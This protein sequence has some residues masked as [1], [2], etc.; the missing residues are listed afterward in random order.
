M[1]ILAFDTTSSELLA[2]C[3]DGRN[4]LG[5][6]A[7]E[8]QRHAEILLR[9]L[10][11]VLAQAKIPLKDIDLFAC[12]RGPGSFMGLRIGLATAKGLSMATG[13]PWVSVSHLDACAAALKD[14]EL[15]IPLIDARKSRVYAALYRKGARIGEYL[16]IALPHLVQRL[17]LEDRIVF[18]G[19][20]AELARGYC[21]ERAGFSV[22]EDDP[23]AVMAELCRL[24]G[25]TLGREGPG[26][27]E[28]GPMYLRE[29]DIG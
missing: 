25:E 21:A 10:E 9:S 15:V 27:P 29:P 5:F 16:D 4:L 24:A 17:A 28:S 13:K 22:H 19:P 26:T 6:D 20:D 8:G 3:M 23:K 2:G 12:S 18:A 1:K 7:A 14:E 11:S